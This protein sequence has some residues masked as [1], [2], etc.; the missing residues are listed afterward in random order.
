MKHIMRR[1][2]INNRKVSANTP[3]LADEF[4]NYI[5]DSCHK[6]GRNQE[7]LAYLLRKLMAKNTMG[8]S[9]DANIIDQDNNEIK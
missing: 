8:Q 5:K 1:Q 7:T 3:P 4:I 9:T 6:S 2:F